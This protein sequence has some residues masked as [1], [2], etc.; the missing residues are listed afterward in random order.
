ML[1]FN[2][3]YLV[4]NFHCTT[5]PVWLTARLQS[6]INWNLEKTA[7]FLTQRQKYIFFFLIWLSLQKGRSAIK[8]IHQLTKL[9]EI[10]WKVLVLIH[11]VIM[12]LMLQKNYFESI[13][14]ARLFPKIKIL[15]ILRLD[16]DLIDN[17]ETLLH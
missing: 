3:K 12:I 4:T 16:L 14:F 17:H 15:N 8:H 2:L 5:L 1:M 11:F 6:Y 7:C 10:I 13:L 9:Y